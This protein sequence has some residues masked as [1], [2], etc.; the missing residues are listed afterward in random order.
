MAFTSKSKQ[1]DINGSWLATDCRPHRRAVRAAS[2][3]A[4]PLSRARQCAVPPWRTPG[5]NWRLGARKQHSCS[6]HA[7]ADHLSGAQD[8]YEVDA[9]RYSAS[10]LGA[11]DKDL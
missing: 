2:G 11:V 9:R 7:T 10:R 5:A 8:A 4:A 6:D 3:I 1:E